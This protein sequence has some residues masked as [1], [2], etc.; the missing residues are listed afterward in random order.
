MTNPTSDKLYTYAVSLTIPIGVRGGV[1]VNNP[2]ALTALASAAW[3]HLKE[4]IAEGS[5]ESV[6]VKAWLLKVT[7]HA[8]PEE[9]PEAHAEQKALPGPQTKLEHQVSALLNGLDLEG[10]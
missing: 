5:Q 7:P 6:Y 4:T 8:H 9:A 3:H 2:N 1:D 10:D